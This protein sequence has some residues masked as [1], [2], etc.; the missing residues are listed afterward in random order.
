MSETL[1]SLHADIG[2][3]CLELIQPDC[4]V[5][6]GTL[7]VH[8]GERWEVQERG[9]IGQDIAA[10][11]REVRQW[12]DVGG[13]HLGEDESRTE[14]GPRPDGDSRDGGDADS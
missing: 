1:A 2:V 9:D 7:E 8:S 10:Q 4:L 3:A 6:V 13:E 14:Y 11:L 5:R 12:R